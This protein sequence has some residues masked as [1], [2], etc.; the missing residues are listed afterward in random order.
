MKSEF[1][2]NP[3]FQIEILSK[4]DDE[5]AAAFQRLMP[6]LTR[7]PPPSR[8]ELE[9][10]VASDSTWVFVARSADG[11]IA[12]TATLA[13]YRTP[14]GLH[15]WIEDVVVD[16]SYRDH[17]IGTRISQEV[18]GHARR[19]GAVTLSLTSHPEREAA[20]RLYQRL[21]F[22]QWQTNLY[23]YPMEG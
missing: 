20:N 5:V 9:E 15:A 23:R 14:T 19:L 2:P 10:T 21:G 1:E 16:A 22:I 11:N 18:I 13:A 12:A 17:G 8:V 7:V 3:P 4:V 6:Q